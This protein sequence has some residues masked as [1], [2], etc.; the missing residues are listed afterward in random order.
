MITIKE[1]KTKKEKKLFAKFPLKLYKN[2]PYYVPSITT[3]EINNF[4]PKKNASLKSCDYKGFLCYKDGELVGRIAG[5]INHKDNELSGVKSI[6]FSRFECIDDIEVFKKLLSV[7]A[8]YGKENGL[9]VLHGP[10]GFNDQ[11]REGMLTF[12]FDQRSTY[13]TNYYYPYFHKNMEKLG[14]EDESKW[15]EFNFKIPT[16]VDERLQRISEKVIEKYKVR[17]IA[18]SM[19]VKEIVARYGSKFFETVNEAYGHLDGYVPLDK[20]M[21]EDVLSQFAVIL[22]MR[23]VSILI[24]EKEDVAGLSICLPSICNALQKSKGKIFSFNILD[25]VKSIKKPTE[26]EMALIAVKKE[27]KNAGL[28]AI[29][30]NRIMRNIIEDKIER[31]ETNPM[32]ETNFSIQ[33]NWKAYEHEV[34]K[35]RQT[36]KIEIDKMLNT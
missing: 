17:E 20:E 31:V 5:I 34:I 2:C 23:Y 16:E 12:G 21:Q 36:Y 10:W 33:Q 29:M 24:D 32:L 19:S 28:N 30:M 14:F 6:R 4:N 3:D 35:R 13:A 7:V 11:D 26:I 25:L 18:D 15:L 8:E 27:Y 1:V 9:E 22:N